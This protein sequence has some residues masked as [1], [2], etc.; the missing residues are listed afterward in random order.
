MFLIQDIPLCDGYLETLTLSLYEGRKEVFYLMTHSTHF[1][2]SYMAS[3][4]YMVKNHSDSERGTR[5]HHIAA[6]VLLHASSHRQDNT[7]HSL[8]YTSRGS[9]AGTRNSPMG[10]PWRIDPT[11]H[12]TNSERSYH[13]ATSRS[14][15]TIRSQLLVVFRNS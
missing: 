12:R 5:C 3:D 4:I 14:S 6:R 9:L 11:T 13:G 10:P 1:I 15:V 8:C 2:Y 7:C